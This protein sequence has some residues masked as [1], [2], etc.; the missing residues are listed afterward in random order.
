M[1]SA[2][3]RANDVRRGACVGTVGVE[4]HVVVIRASDP[5]WRSDL[6]GGWSATAQHAG[7]IRPGRGARTRLLGP[8]RHEPYVD[9]ARFGQDP[10]DPDPPLENR[11]AR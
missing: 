3:V 9:G 2:E 4:V 8:I 7:Q 10:S 1:S 5:G 11:R 6:R